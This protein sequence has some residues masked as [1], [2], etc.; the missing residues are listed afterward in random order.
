MDKSEEEEVQ[1][2]SESVTPQKVNSDCH[3]DNILV[4]SNF[5]F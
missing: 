4:C 5:L 1:H 3:K 2:T